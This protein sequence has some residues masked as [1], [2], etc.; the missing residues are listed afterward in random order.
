MA[1]GNPYELGSEVIKMLIGRDPESL[2]CAYGIMKLNVPESKK[3]SQHFL[4]NYPCSEVVEARE[5][6]GVHF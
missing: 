2:Q 1:L 4:V 6:G 5:N 3:G